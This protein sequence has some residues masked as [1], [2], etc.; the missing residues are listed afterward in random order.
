MKK[1]KL[2]LNNKINVYKQQAFLIIVFFCTFMLFRV[3]IFELFWILEVIFII[4]QIGL[5]K[6][7]IIMK[8]KL[9]ISLFVSWIISTLYSFVSDIP[10]SYKMNS[11]IAII[12]LIPTFF[13]ISYCLGDMKNKYFV[14]KIK[15][16]IVISCSIQLIWCLL[17]FILYNFANI[18]LNQVIFSD[19][20]HVMENPSSYKFGVYNPS[21]MCWHP[22]FMAP[23]VIIAF[24]ISESYI[25]KI[26]AI[27]DSIICNN[28]TALIGI[29][30]CLIVSIIIS[31]IEFV[32]KSQKK[33]QKKIILWILVMIIIFVPL[34]IHYNVFDIIQTKIVDIYQRSAGLVNDGGSA[35]AHIRYY[36]AFPEIVKKENI[37]KLL[38]GYGTSNSGFPISKILGQYTNLESW[39]VESDVMNQLYSNGIIGFLLFYGFLLYIAIKGFKIDKRYFIVMVGL[40]LSGITYNIQFNWVI[41]IE[42]LFYFMVKAKMKLSFNSNKK[43]KRGKNN[44]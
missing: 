28:A 25:I 20:L 4:I 35:N 34:I 19:I 13:S 30:I 22:A 21:G 39:S 3:N 17:Q 2:K 36:T 31:I 32:K 42:F 37:G 15:K 26:L 27:V 5:Q 40:I 9:I 41:F 38:L 18:D 24:S 10:T 16:I 12:Y 33:T 29:S 23:I 6:K 43:Y 44:E 14:E 8:D 1:L 7:I 11:A